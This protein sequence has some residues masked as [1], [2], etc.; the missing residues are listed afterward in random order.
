M[1]KTIIFLKKKRQI[2]PIM[3]LTIMASITL[4]YFVLGVLQI[5]NVFGNLV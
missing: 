5:D 2:I 4:I 1:K 3:V